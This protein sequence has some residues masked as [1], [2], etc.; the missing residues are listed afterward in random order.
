MGV[1]PATVARGQATVEV[2]L[3]LP[4]VVLLMA[5]A[6]QLVLLVRDELHLLHAARAS[7]RAAV[8]DPRPA[9]VEAALERADLDLDGLEVEVG[10][11][12]TP[13]ELVIVEVWARP[14]RVPLV[15]A[16]VSRVVLHERVVA[17]VE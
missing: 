10:G 11:S 2:A 7:V 17:M 12:H 5:L 1:R 8:V 4:L 6:A 15:G 3:L 16:V 13:G 9:A 14:T